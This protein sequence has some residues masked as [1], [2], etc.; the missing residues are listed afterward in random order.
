[1]SG[2]RVLITGAASGIG[3][4][5]AIEMGRRGHSLAISARRLD[6]LAEVAAEVERGNEP[7]RDR[8]PRRA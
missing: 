1:M 4:A 8:P 7:T 6:R 2:K 3:R 5:L